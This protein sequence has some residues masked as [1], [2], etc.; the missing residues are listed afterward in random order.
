MRRPSSNETQSLQ[1][2]KFTWTIHTSCAVP[3]ILYALR[4]AESRYPPGRFL[5]FSDNL[6]NLTMFSVMRR[7]HASGFKAGFV[8]SFRWIP[9]ELSYPDNRSR[10]LD[11]DHDPIKFLLHVLAQRNTRSATRI[12]CLHH[13]WTWMLVKVTLHL[14][15]MSRCRMSNQ[16]HHPMISRAAAVSTQWS[17]DLGMYDCISDFGVEW[18]HGSLDSLTRCGL[19]SGPV[20]SQ[21]LDESQMQSVVVS[22]YWYRNLSRTKFN[23]DF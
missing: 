7:I 19:P 5:I 9:S 11:R 12:V 6:N 21:F 22:W 4:H 23:E 20:G 17:Y 15:L 10:V 1:L 2:H 18:S 13:R 8:S 16:L 3:S 14:I